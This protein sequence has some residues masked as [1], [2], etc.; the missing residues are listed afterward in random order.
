MTEAGMLTEIDAGQLAE[1]FPAALGAQAVQAAA[2]VA[3][4]LDAQQ[5]TSRFALSVRGD[6]IIVPRRLRFFRVLPARFSFFRSAPAPRAAP[7]G[8]IALMVRCLETRSSDGFERQR[9]VRALLAD[10]RPWT[11]PFI[12]ALI[13][14]YVIEILEDVHAALPSIDAAALAAVL[15]DNPAYWRLTRQ[16]VA[17][18]WNF[19]Y[20][21]RFR[22]SDYVGFKLIAELQAAARRSAGA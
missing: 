19:Y 11:A 13:G 6:R 14:E 9:A 12:V 20:R 21:A 2:L 3:R 5:W 8:D 1:A 18:Y 10:V 16:R 17:S 4:D 22:R 15:A 7:T